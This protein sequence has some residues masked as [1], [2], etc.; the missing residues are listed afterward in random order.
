MNRAVPCSDISEILHNDMRKF[1]PVDGDVDLVIVD[2]GVNDGVLLNFDN[3]S[4]N[5]M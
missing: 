2:T 5:V 3:D 1:L 4:K